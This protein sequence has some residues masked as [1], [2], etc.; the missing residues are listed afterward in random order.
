[1]RLLI[2]H[3]KQ[4]EDDTLGLRKFIFLQIQ[5]LYRQNDQLNNQENNRQINGK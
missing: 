2:G 5:T 4:S 1:M 3:N